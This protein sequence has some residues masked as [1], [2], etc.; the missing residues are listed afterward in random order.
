MRMELETL[1]NWNRAYRVSVILLNYVWSAVE[2]AGGAGK[3]TFGL[4]RLANPQFP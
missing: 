2:G 1:V 4:M 3:L